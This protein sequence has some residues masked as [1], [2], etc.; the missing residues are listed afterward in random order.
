[1]KIV[2]DGVPIPKQR[3]RHGKTKSGF[4]IT[5]DAQYQEKER[6]KKEMLVAYN[7]ALN[8]KNILECL[9]ASHLAKV[10]RFAVHF[11]F[12]MPIAQSGSIQL[13]NM[14][15]WGLIHHT[16]KPDC[17]NLIKFYEDCANGILF[18]D[19]SQIT[20]GSF[21]KKYSKNPRTEIEIMEDKSSSVHKSVEEIL[22][23][24]NPTEFQEL[25]DQMHF[26]IILESVEVDDIMSCETRNNYLETIAYELSKF[27]KTFAPKFNK[28]SK[29]TLP[30]KK[31]Y[32]PMEGKTLC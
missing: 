3:A 32:V 31:K 18:G 21:K 4:P 27:S 12:H 2:I 30:E 23:I 22:K 20:S 9:E 25:L 15:E 17:S 24:F 8:S 7:R 6:V 19:D 16:G 29:I 13:K 5:F 1:M 14:K 26:L 28:V 10:E 11:T